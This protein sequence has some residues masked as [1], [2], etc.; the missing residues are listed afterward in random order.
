[1]RLSKDEVRQYLFNA[2]FRNNA[3]LY[4]VSICHCESNYETT[5][6]NTNNEDSRGLMQINVSPNANPQYKNLDL[7][8]P[9]INCN[10]AYEIF[11]NRGRTFRDWTCAK[12]LGL[13]YPGQISP[14]LAVAGV[15]IIAGIVLYLT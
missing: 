13:E 15:A 8:N 2:G 11:I 4:A 10:V 5:A 3:L 12:M 14:I 1:M 6:H 9:Q 7:F